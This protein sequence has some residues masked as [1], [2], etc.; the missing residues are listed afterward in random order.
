MTVRIEVLGR[1]GVLEAAGLLGRAL[2][3][4]VGVE[5]VA[6]EKLFGGDPPGRVS[7]VLAARRDGGRLLGVAAWAGRWLKLLAVDPAA[8]GRGVGAAL[9]A[10]CEAAARVAGAQ[11]VRTLDHPGNYVSPGL[12]DRYDHGW[13]RRRGYA[14]VEKNRNLRVALGGNA[15]VTRARAD[16]AGAR[17]AAAG[18]RIV[19]LASTST[20]TE[21]AAVLALAEKAFAPVWAFELAKA[22]RGP[23]GVFAAFRGDAAV[24]FAAIDGNNAGLGWFG[25]AGTLPDERGR[26]IGEALLLECLLAA[27]ARGRDHAIIAWIGPEE[28]YRK[29]AGAVP[30]R[31]FVVLSRSLAGDSA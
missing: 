7:G 31:S 6:E 3:L 1:E 28:F 24:G 19:K 21:F 22:T 29:V 8:R 10:A 23:G 27:Q 5:V 11:V 14:V 18:L 30:D 4:D 17:V 20:S 15:L 2:P 16:A 26:G 25:P 12:D 13:L 9:L